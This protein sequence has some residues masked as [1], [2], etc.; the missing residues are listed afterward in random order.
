MN[1][2]VAVVVGL[3]VVAVVVASIVFGPAEERRAGPPLGPLNTYEDGSR[4]A[5]ILLE[6]LGRDVRIGDF[7]NGSAVTVLID[8]ESLDDRGAE[9]VES[10]LVD[11]GTVVLLQPDDRF[12]ESAGVGTV[13]GPLSC[14]IE[15]LASVDELTVG[16]SVGID[17]PEGAQRCFEVGRGWL[18]AAFDVGAGRLVAVG[19]SRPFVNQWLTVDDNAAFVVGVMSLTDGP[20]N[21]VPTDRFD[22]VGAGDKTL[23]E[24]ISAEA[25]AVVAMLAL[26]MVAYAA[27]R[28]RRLG[29]PVAESDA[30]EIDATELTR[31][32]AR[33]YERTK[34][35]DVGSARMRDLLA[36]DL[37]RRWRIDASTADADEVVARVRR[38]AYADDALEEALSRSTPQ[39]DAAFVRYVAAAVEARR[40]VSGSTRND[41]H[42]GSA[43]TD[44]KRSDR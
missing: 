23:V 3:L 19:S 30:V 31:A 22:T 38:S 14:T 9:A 2:S 40:V 44:Q 6:E 8:P 41:R 16:V 34:A 10:Y 5:W 20:I 17:A 42:S 13:E 18:V 37:M 35:R 29:K 33:L 24:L 25:W 26:S 21:V 12:V 36:D 27:A 28:A 43:A 11:G 1:R 15:S 39:D 32:T 4:A 7:D